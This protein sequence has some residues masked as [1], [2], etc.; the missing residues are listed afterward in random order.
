MAMLVFNL[1]KRLP[2]S[3]SCISNTLR[4][5]HVARCLSDIPHEKTFFNRK[6]EFA[7]F[8]KAF[9]G[10]LELHVVLGPPSSGKT[11]LIREV[12][13]RG[14]FKPL[15]LDCRLGQFDSPA[16]VYD[17][18]SMQFET[19]FEYQKKFLL[20][21]LPEMEIKAKIP[22]FF[23]LNFKLFDKKEKEITSKNVNNL[24]NAIA[25]ALP[26][27]NLWKGYNIPSPILVID[28]ANSLN[29]LG[30]SSV[31]GE[32]LLK[33]FLDWL[34]LNT[35]Q[36]N[37]F[38]V[39]LTSSD[40][41]FY[42]W[43]EERLH[44]P[45]VHSYVVGDLSKEEAEEYFEKHVLP[46]NGCKELEGKFDHVRKITGTRMLIID[47]YVKEYKIS[48]GKLKDSE[49][50]VYESE[51]SKLVRGLYPKKVKYS[52]RPNQP[53]WTGSDLLKTMKA[54][55]EAEN[56]GYI[57][58]EN[59]ISVIGSNQVDSLVDYNFLHH[60]QSS[61]YAYDIIKPPNKIILTA[62]NQPSLRAIEVVL[63]DFHLIS[64]VCNDRQ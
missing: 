37:R 11:A 5:G 33:T 20:E 64:H 31:E 46:K 9:R 21:N 4:T 13:T 34:V 48:N 14:N 10:D 15:F 43:I 36:T 60:R 28:E 59:L 42:N 53:L 2:T 6:R 55:V 50:S 30:Y 62:M 29:R 63:S 44:N 24:L 38:H 12:T 45:N 19:F 22:Y 58:V 26:N 35:K 49:F 32:V 40:S 47:K 1:T 27:R 61:N 16:D 54:L 57:L 52:D 18:I 51:Y 39:V 17:S 3:V 25:N 41:F 8:E 7:E 56:Q 23:E